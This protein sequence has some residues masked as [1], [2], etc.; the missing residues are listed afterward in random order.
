MGRFIGRGSDSFNLAEFAFHLSQN[1]IPFWF[2]IFGGKCRQHLFPC[3]DF[4]VERAEHPSRDPWHSSE[5]HTIKLPRG[6]KYCELRAVLA[7]IPLS[8]G[9]GGIGAL[10]WYE[11]WE[12]E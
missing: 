9:A 12:A 6:L 2:G 10:A 3:P 1:G 5:V 7:D 11:R 8:L 4:A